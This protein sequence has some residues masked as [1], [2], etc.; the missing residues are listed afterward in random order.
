M[1]TEYAFVLNEKT[2]SEYKCLLHLYRN[3]VEAW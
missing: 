1:K 2:I 3:E